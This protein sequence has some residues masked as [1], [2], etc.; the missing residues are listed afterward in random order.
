MDSVAITK[1]SFDDPWQV[2]A[3]MVSSQMIL[4]VAGGMGPPPP[5][6]FLFHRSGRVLKLKIVN[7]SAVA[8]TGF[9]IEL[10]SVFGLPS[11]P[12]GLSFGKINGTNNNFELFPPLEAP[13]DSGLFE[14]DCKI[15]NGFLSPE[16]K[17]RFPCS[18]RFQQV[19]FDGASLE[20]KLTFSA[21]AVPAGKDV[22][23][24]FL[25]TE[26]DPA[27][28]FFFIFLRPQSAPN[29]PK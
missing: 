19:S 9:E 1:G 2:A 12:D 27:N 5:G 21:G 7:Q 16:S 17:R 20:D 25:V 6:S 26:N 8:W 29:G 3:K 14:T 28:I 13:F 23:F 10:R 24:T 22:T 15:Q 4:D 11:G 18:D